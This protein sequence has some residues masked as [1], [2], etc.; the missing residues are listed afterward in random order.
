MSE[1]S[2]NGST[3]G[4]DNR[5][6]AIVAAIAL[7]ALLALAALAIAVSAG[8]TDG[9]AEGAGT[10]LVGKVWKWL[11]FTSPSGETIV[12]DEPNN[13][14]IEFTSDG[15]VRVQ[16]DCNSG[17][18]VYTVDNGTISVEVQAMTLALCPPGSLSDQ[19]VQRLN[20]VAVYRVEGD[21]LLMDLPADAGTMRFTASSVGEKAKI[22][23]NLLGKNWQWFKFTSPTN[24]VVVDDPSKYSVEFL[25]DGVIRVKADCNNGGG[26]Y[27]AS[28]GN[29]DIEVQQMTMAACPPESL[30]D[31]FVQGLNTA[32]VYGVD[33]DVLMM[34]LPA[35]AGTMLLSPNP[36]PQQPKVDPN[37]IGKVW[38]WY[39]FQSPVGEKIIVPDAN[40]YTVEF[41][42]D[43]R[44][45]VKA[46]C[47]SGQGVH[48]A[49]GSSISI[50]V[51]AM[52]LAM[53]APESLSDQFVRGLN[54]A[55][56]YFFQG[57]DLF[58][59]LPMDSG[60]MAFS[61]NPPPPPAPT[62]T[63]APTATP[64]AVP[65]PTPAP[66]PTSGPQTDPRLVGTVWKW[67]EFQS[68]VGEKIAPSNPNQYTVEFTSDG[69]VR[70]RADCNT[71]NGVYSASG[72]NINIQ[73]RAMTLAACAP[74]SFSD[75]FVQGLNSVAV[76]GFD[77]EV[78]LMDLPMD[79]GTISLAE[80]P[81]T[82]QPPQVDSNL[83]GT[84]NWTRFAS[85]AGETI[86]SP[87]PN[88][89]TVTFASD[90]TVSVLADCN[91]GNGAYTADGSSINIQ[92]MAMTR[93]LCAP[94]SF[95]D[96]FVEALNNAAIYFFQNSNL[97]MDLPMDSGTIT[98]APG[99]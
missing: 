81:P 63:P 41:F 19:Y 27:A 52:T 97:L 83:F 21:I 15:T 17:S 28:D 40:Q 87:D 61:E 12:V 2:S 10:D 79:S 11:E 80:T 49:D 75:Q 77:G 46:D 47:N 65:T 38:K 90:G 93:A 22:D 1:S 37:L 60:T 34:D 4:S 36:P 26:I 30:S 33:G 57:G 29:I 8:D 72:G 20:Q 31:P 23:P 7:V 50:E 54:T 74:G 53:C 88:R 24:E 55:A 51:Q 14:T 66:T 6:I 32:V 56:I 92:V 43:G 84:W 25:A 76:Y 59:D 18:G 91:R 98:F 35:D 82:P 42:S 3:S 67:F 58:M 39:Q 62:P 44:V 16:A 78:L 68:P 48:T 95:S 71:G 70:V 9:G 85:P 5:I 13:Y 89:Y 69:V 94:G 45:S 99:Q 86:S 96:Q 73:V 64:T